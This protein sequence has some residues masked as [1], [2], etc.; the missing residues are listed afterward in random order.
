M[1]PKLFLRSVIVLARV[2]I[3]MHMQYLSGDLPDQGKTPT[4]MV[5]VELSLNSLDPVYFLPG[6]H[7][8]KKKRIFIRKLSGNRPKSNFLE[9]R[10]K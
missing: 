8:D 7:W 3:N 4:R 1:F 2:H 10:K 9:G 5:P 6:S